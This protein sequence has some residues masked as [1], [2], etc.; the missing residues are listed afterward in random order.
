M[1]YSVSRRLPCLLPDHHGVLI[2]DYV[3][4]VPNKEYYLHDV[5]VGYCSMFL[6][7]GV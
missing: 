3:N 2:L 4:S 5:Y 1:A 6:N 7:N